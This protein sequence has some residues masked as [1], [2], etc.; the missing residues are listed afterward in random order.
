MSLGLMSP[1]RSVAWR[2]VATSMKHEFGP[3]A[4]RA[5]ET[6]LDPSAADDELNGSNLISDSTDN[7]QIFKTSI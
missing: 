3:E 2:S 1:W 4:Y 7:L 6:E 5:C